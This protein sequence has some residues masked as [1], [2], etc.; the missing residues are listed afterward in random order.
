[1]RIV[2][3]QTFLG[4]PAGTLFAKVETP[5]TIDFG[6]LEIKGDTCVGVDFYVQRIIG[7]IAGTNDSGEWFAAYEAMVDGEER[8]PDFAIE[9]R[10]GLFD[11][12]QLFAV[13]D[14]DDTSALIDRLKEAEAEAF[15]SPNP[16][17]PHSPPPKDVG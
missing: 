11:A 5:P 16:T 14:A 4:L 9:S 8:K 2:D 3:R 7:D 6:P 17:S 15:G 10:D 12:D 1:M 13:Y